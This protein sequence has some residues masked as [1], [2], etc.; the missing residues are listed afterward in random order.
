MSG[1]L[2]RVMLIG[3]LCAAPEVRSFQS[4]GRVANLRLATNER[5]KDKNTGEQKEA[6]EYHTIAI[7]SEG[8]VNVCERYL[9]KG[10]KIYV[11]GQ[12]KTRKWQDQ[13]GQDR[14]S[15]EIVLQGFNGTLVMLD[16][17]PSEQR[18]E[19]R[20]PYDDSMNHGAQQQASHAGLDD[21]I[22]F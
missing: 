12:L 7:F 11:E 17:A 22:P 15:T 2:N 14:Y 21:Q 1:S 18:G 4:G 6:V 8:L 20:K 10:S 13:N 9:N 5:W 19:A 3:N 16:G